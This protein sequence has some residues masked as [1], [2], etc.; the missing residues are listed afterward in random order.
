MKARWWPHCRRRGLE[1]N[2]PV[3]APVTQA[4]TGAL[5]ARWC[6]NL[7]APHAL[8]F[9]NHPRVNTHI[10]Q[11]WA[12]S[13]S[14]L[15]SVAPALLFAAPNDSATDNDA[16]DPAHKPPALRDACGQLPLSFEE[17]RGQAPE[18]FDFLARGPGY[19]LLLEADSA[20]F[21][22]KNATHPATLRMRVVGAD[23]RAEAEQMEELEGKVNYFI[24]NDPAK[25]RRDVPTFGRVRYRQVYRGI[26]LVYYGNQRQ[27]EY[28]FIVEAGADWRR[29]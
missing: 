4:T 2:A 21:E 13:F 5:L 23:A 14:M 9:Y 17:N 15:L 18:E 16:A 29:I 6:P 22:L 7:I 19:T 10:T 12:V 26:D 1:G 3:I 11:T 20:T 8:L 28:D 24:G 25:W 27:L